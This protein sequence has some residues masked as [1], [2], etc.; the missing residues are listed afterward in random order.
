MSRPWRVA[1]LC[2]KAGGASQGY[3]LAARDAGIGI[4]ITGVDLEPQPNY[5]FDFVQCDALGFDLSGFDLA[6]ASPTCKGYSECALINPD[7]EHPMQIPQFRAMLAASGIPWVIENVETAPL[8]DPVTLCRAMWPGART[9]RHR[10]FESSFLIPQPDEPEHAWPMAK[11]GRPVRDGEFLHIAGHFSNVRLAR[12][13]MGL[14]WMTR[15]ELAQAIPVHY[16]RHVG[17]AALAHRA[18][19]AA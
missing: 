8:I 17:A 7:A 4:E 1:D 15:D 9:Y 12:A 5:P 13:T 16:G 10:L 18:L 14:P 11:M 3:L 2:C 19:L 6:H